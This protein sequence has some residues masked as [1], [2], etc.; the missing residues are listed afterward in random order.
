[1]RAFTA[2]N[3]SSAA[4]CAALIGLLA[5]CQSTTYPP[6]A[7]PPAHADAP[8][9]SVGDRWIY[10]HTD[11]YTN[12]PGGVF[13]HTITAI[14]GNAVTV[15][16]RNERGDPVATDQFT[17][18]W[19]WLDKPMTN[20]QRFRYSPPYRA[21]EFPLAPGARWSVQMTVVDVADQ[22]AYDLARVDG[23]ALDWQRVTVPAGSF[24]A[25][26]VERF[27]FSG[28]NTYR[29]TQE[30]IRERDWYAPAVNNIVVGSYRSE[31]R[32]LTLAGEDDTGW[33][34]NDWTL[35]ELLEYRPAQKQ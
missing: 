13:T 34:N 15:E 31:Y 3:L 29:R 25:V 11:A 35:V 27:A 16:T 19:N 2:S 9:L 26:R 20:L 18:D 30:V 1:M 4:S 21:F 28:V 6:V 5:G 7:N 33:V 23:R 22:K 10:R 17:R 32:D 24:D 14:N 12:L 8:R